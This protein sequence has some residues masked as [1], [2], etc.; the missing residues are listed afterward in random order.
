MKCPSCGSALRFDIAE[1]RLVCDS[2]G[3]SYDPLAYSEDNNADMSEWGGAR[4]YRCRNCGAELLSMNDEAVSYC[5][6][7]GSE[8]VLEEEISGM[9]EPKQIIPFRITK[10]ECRSIY[11]EALKHKRY[12]PKE[13]KEDAFIER[14][15]P[16]YIPYWMYSVKFREEPFE[17]K[18]YRN[19]TSNGYD[20]HEEY[21]ITA[22]IRDKGLYGVPYDAS[23]NF[24]DQ[25][26]EDIAPFSK[27]DLTP[28]RSAYLAGMYADRPNVSAD[29][30]QDEVMKE[31]VNAAAADIR[32]GLNMTGLKMPSGKKLKKLLEARYEGAEAVFLPVWF[33]TWRKGN[34]VAYAV[35]NGQT[36]KMHIDL[37]TDMRIF[38]RNTLL[39]AVVLFVL[40]TLFVSATSRFVL[41]FSALLVY[42][43]G[44]RYRK[45]LKEIRDREN[46]IFDKGYLLSD[47]DELPMSEQARKRTNRLSRSKILRTLSGALMSV[48]VVFALFFGLLAVV[49]DGIMTY[50]AARNLTFVI[51]IAEAVLCVR[52]ILIALNLKNKRSVIPVLLALAAVVYSFVI[53]YREPVMDWWYYL[54]S[55][56]CLG[57]ATVMCADL[58][59][60]YNEKATRPLPSFYTREGGQDHA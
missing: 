38:L 44:R 16:F 5:M 59:S 6:Y 54:G 51:M 9:N 32:K 36:G 23:R 58:I 57:A 53:A 35:V 25:I 41:W 11:R 48:V 15:R 60:R 31:A 49:W 46:H 18:G 40:L 20:Y 4:M 21:D 55:L 37:P 43:A 27:K 8:A 26:A 22:E 33:L 7:C 13:F 2:C 12:L 42:L 56:L 45:E 39:A 17:L 10:D 52:T 50:E 47:E 3:Q 29:L 24:D 34:R 19:Y 30:Y 1:H 14:F 28:Y